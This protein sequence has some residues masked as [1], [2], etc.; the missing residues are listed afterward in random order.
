[1]VSDRLFVYFAPLV[2]TAEMASLRGGARPRA[3]SGLRVEA[4]LE[5]LFSP[6]KISTFARRSQPLD[7]D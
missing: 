5:G 6:A 1:M 7:V 3:A 4:N 2:P